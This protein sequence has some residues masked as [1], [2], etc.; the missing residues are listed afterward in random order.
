MRNWAFKQYEN[1]ETLLDEEGYEDEL[2]QRQGEWYVYL[3]KGRVPYRKGTYKDGVRHGI[4]FSLKPDGKPRTEGTGWV[5][6]VTFTQ[7]YYDVFH[8]QLQEER[9]ENEK[10]QISG[11]YKSYFGT[12]D[13]ECVGNYNCNK[14]VGHWAWY[15]PTKMQ[16]YINSEEKEY[17]GYPSNNWGGF[18]PL[19]NEWNA[20]QQLLPYADRD[21]IVYCEGEYVNNY[22]EGVWTWYRPTGEKWFERTYREGRK[23]GT[24]RGW[25]KD[26]TLY[27]EAEYNDGKLSGSGTF[28]FNGNTTTYK[29][30]GKICQHI[31]NLEGIDSI[32]WLPNEERMDDKQQWENAIWHPGDY[33]KIRNLADSGS[34][35]RPYYMESL[36]DHWLSCMRN[37]ISEDKKENIRQL[38]IMQSCIEYLN[39]TYNVKVPLRFLQNLFYAGENDY[40]IPF[41]GHNVAN[42]FFLKSNHKWDTLFYK[43]EYDLTHKGPKDFLDIALVNRW[44]MPDMVE[45]LIMMGT[46]VEKR[47]LETIDNLRKSIQ[48]DLDYYADKSIDH[49]DEPGSDFNQKNVNDCNKIIKMFEKELKKRN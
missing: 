34:I 26:E 46:K 23:H 40:Y 49:S 13:L 39:N 14:K 43:E 4:W 28:Y 11:I 10:R 12:G 7:I 16:I 41:V 29:L 18:S 27:G 6:G 2:G 42:Y 21:G 24:W 31:T 32:I 8:K 48:A 15:Y 36:C 44:P 1:P 38:N 47:H 33:N 37:Q 3:H 17:L 5:N 30:L 25:N 9:W 35:I 22:P 19:Y 20:A 45:Y